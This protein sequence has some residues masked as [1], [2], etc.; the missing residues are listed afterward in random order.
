MMMAR[1]EKAIGALVAQVALRRLGKYRKF[2]KGMVKE[3]TVVLPGM[4]E[5]AEN[6][7]SPELLPG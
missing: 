3:L 6:I 1:W 5:M 2:P 7:F 4:P